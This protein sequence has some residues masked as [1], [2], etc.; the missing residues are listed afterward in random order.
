[1]LLVDEDFDAPEHPAYQHMQDRKAH[2]ARHFAEI[3]PAD[4]AAKL[5]EAGFAEVE[6]STVTMADRPVKMVHA[7]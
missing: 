2:R 7:T 1:V 6:G 4:V 3:V 5:S